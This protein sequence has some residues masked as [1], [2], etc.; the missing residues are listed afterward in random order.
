MA[1]SVIAP[2]SKGQLAGKRP[3]TVAP[4]CTVSA[5]KS[6]ATGITSSP[7][8]HGDQ[9]G[10][11]RPKSGWRLAAASV[12]ATH[13]RVTPKYHGLSVVEVTTTIAPSQA[14]QAKP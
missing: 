5:L 13:N 11:L 12:T 4:T 14:S 2:P 7:K 10:A 1:S 8:R 6:A 9:I 3:N